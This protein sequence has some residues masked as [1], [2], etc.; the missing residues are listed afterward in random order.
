MMS[1]NH[2]HNPCSCC[3]DCSYQAPHRTCEEEQKRL[4]LLADVGAAGPEKKNPAN[5]L[6]ENKLARIS[7]DCV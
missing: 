5:V 7:P 6:E 1:Y 3:V 4:Q 2:I